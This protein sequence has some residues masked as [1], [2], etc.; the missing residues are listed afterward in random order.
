[1]KS[2]NKK[3]LEW[4][5]F[6]LIIICFIVMGYYT[7]Q[8][9]SNQK[10]E[11]SDVVKVDNYYNPDYLFNNDYIKIASTIGDFNVERKEVY[12]Y[13]D[14]D[15]TLYIKYTNG[16]TSYN[17]HITN[18]PE[19]KVTVYYNNLYD[20]YYELVALTEE[21]NLYYI[22]LDLKSKKDYKFYDVGEGINGVYVP[23]YDKSKVYV[24]K[25]DNLTTNFIFSDDENNLKYL[26][27]EKKE[28]ILR[29]NLKD[30]KPYFD[31]VC[32]SDTSIMCNDIMIY[33]TFE[34]KLVYN[35][36]DEV[37]KNDLDE[38]II[39]KDMFATLEIDSKKQ[40][41]LDTISFSV[42]NKKY[43][44]IFTVYIVDKEDNFYKL[45]INKEVLKQ[46]QVGS[47][48][49]SSEKR[50]KQLVIDEKEGN[51]LVHVIYVDGEETKITEDINKKIITSTVYDKNKNKLIEL[52]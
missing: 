28:Y 9:Y 19:G 23:S 4:C 32:A 22:S 8:S 13:L 31:Y 33:Q 17:K 30:V 3:A 6:S 48:L 24:N 26:D 44:Y 46:K 42:L 1:M 43:D 36:I 47:A 49:I 39:V 5:A 16:K 52:N 50:V 45:E 14:K 38:D 40:I 35:Y 41:D 7:Y 15:N 51:K 25:T 2:R 34:N 29:D 10:N 18:L 12:M 20:D 21:K 27:Y 11:K 37:V